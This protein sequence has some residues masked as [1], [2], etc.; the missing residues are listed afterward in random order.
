MRKISEM[1]MEEIKQELFAFSKRSQAQ[2]AKMAE[3]EEKTDFIQLVPFP[4]FIL[5][6]ASLGF[7]ILVGIF[8]VTG[9]PVSAFVLLLALAFGVPSLALFVSGFLLYLKG[10]PYC[11][12]PLGE[13]VERYEKNLNLAF[14]IN[15]ST[16]RDHMKALDERGRDLTVG[17]A[18]LIIAYA[19]FF[20]R[21][22]QMLDLKMKALGNG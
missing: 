3:Q 1:S 4:L 16:I 18:E 6:F 10:S 20:R 11:F 17:E 12:H 13:V 15:S 8:E 22:S 9:T 19:K 2:I 7:G 21:K 14:S 5:M